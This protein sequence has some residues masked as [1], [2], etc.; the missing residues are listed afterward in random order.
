MS[1]DLSQEVSIYL[2]KPKQL[3]QLNKPKQLKELK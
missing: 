3:K 1:L 2:S